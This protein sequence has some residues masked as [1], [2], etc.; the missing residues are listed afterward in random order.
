[1][2]KELTPQIA[3][4]YLGC[5]VETAAGYGNIYSVSADFARVNF[6][7]QKPM[8]YLG[9]DEIKLVLRPLSDMTEEENTHVQAIVDRMGAVHDAANMAE[10][11]A[12]LTSKHFDLFGL[13]E[14]G[15]AVEKTN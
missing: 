14:S 6:G 10:I 15:L 12:Y 4:M 2:Q 9:F 7:W 5:E 13:I 11:T 3:A 8:E 1:M